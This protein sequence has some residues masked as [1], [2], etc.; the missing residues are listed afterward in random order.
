[1]QSGYE[2]MGRLKIDRVIVRQVQSQV[3]KQ[4]ISKSFGEGRD[5]FRLMKRASIL[6]IS[7]QYLIYRWMVRRHSTCG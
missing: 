2:L 1:M 3:A 5:G 4:Q 6:I 7:F